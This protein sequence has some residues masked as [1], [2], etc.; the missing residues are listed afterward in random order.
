M[1]YRA[2]LSTKNSKV[3]NPHTH[4]P[5]SFIIPTDPTPRDPIKVLTQL[6]SI[7]KYF[8]NFVFVFV[9]CKLCIMTNMMKNT[10]GNSKGSWMSGFYPL[11][12][13]R[14]LPPNLYPAW[15]LVATSSSKAS[16]IWQTPRPPP[17][18]SPSPSWPS[19]RLEFIER[20]KIWILFANIETQSHRREHKK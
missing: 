10:A 3:Q 15:S 9:S 7:D 8:L 1:T 12:F 16:L 13:W 4:N 6:P 18:F 19:F 11:G 2:R 14:N 5:N 17:S 20:E